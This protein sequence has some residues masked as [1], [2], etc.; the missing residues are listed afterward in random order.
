RRR[1]RAG[2]ARVVSARLHNREE[3]KRKDVREG[4]HVRVQRAGDVIPQ[5]IE[6]VTPEGEKRGPEWEMP[7]RC[8]SCGTALAE[9]GPFPSCPNAFGCRAQLVG[10]I[11]HFVS[12]DALDI[13]GLGE[14]TAKQLVD[15]KIV[16]DLPDLFDVTVERLVALEGFAEKSPTAL[17]A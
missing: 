16:E 7:S 14:E 6:V 2:A 11:V 8:P 10:R 13:E 4:D 12:R 1:A 3:V 5:V 9:R 17:V 15:E